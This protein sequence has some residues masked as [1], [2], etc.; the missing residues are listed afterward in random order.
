MIWFFFIY[1][2]QLKFYGTE[3]ITNTNNNKVFE[4]R[5]QCHILK[6]SNGGQYLIAG[7]LVNN[8]FVIDSYTREILNSF[9][10]KSRGRFNDIIFSDDDI[11]VYVVCNN[12]YI[13]DINLSFFGIIKFLYC[14][15]DIYNKQKKL[16]IRRL[17][18]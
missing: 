4:E 13:Y 3:Q 8:I 14:Y 6:F 10:I 2:K 15:N 11:Y 17:L 1:Y 12:G 18:I 5:I 9:N 7:N 16:Y